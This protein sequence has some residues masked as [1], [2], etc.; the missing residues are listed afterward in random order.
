MLYNILRYVLYHFLFGHFIVN[1]MV[2]NQ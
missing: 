2:A 1:F